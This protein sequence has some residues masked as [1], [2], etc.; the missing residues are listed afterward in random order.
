MVYHRPY[1]YAVDLTGII[2]LSNNKERYANY[3][4]K[5]DIMTSQG[6]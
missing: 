1:V 2:T 6:V 3:T 5:L 4:D